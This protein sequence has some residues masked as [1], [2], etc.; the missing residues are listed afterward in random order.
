MMPFDMMS[1]VSNTSMPPHTSHP[2][3]WSPATQGSEWISDLL[4]IPPIRVSETPEVMTSMTNHEPTSPVHESS[5]D[6]EELL[7]ETSLER[8]D[9]EALETWETFFGLNIPYD[10]QGQKRY[11]TEHLRIFRAVSRLLKQGRT[12]EDIRQALFAQMPQ[13]HEP[14]P[15]TQTQVTHETGSLQS[16]LSRQQTQLQQELIPSNEDDFDHETSTSVIP[17]PPAFPTLAKPTGL[18]SASQASLPEDVVRL[19]Q[20]CLQAPQTPTSTQEVAPSKPSHPEVSQMVLPQLV[21]SHET[22]D[23]LQQECHLL[24]ERLLESEKRNSHLFQTNE[25]FTEKLEAMAQALQQAKEKSKEGDIMKLLEDKARLHKDLLETR[26]QKDTIEKH[27]YEWQAHAEL[28]EGALTTLTQPSLETFYGVWQEHVVLQEVLLDEVGIQM[29]AR[30]ERTV[31]LEAGPLMQQFGN[32]LMLT[33]QY[34]YDN[35]PH[36]ERRE[37]SIL[38]LQANGELSGPLFV[39]YWFEK[40]LMAK[41]LYRF[42]AERSTV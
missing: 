10:A 23:R 1:G 40:R 20:R 41:A 22:I 7:Q 11:S 29:D 13:S 26:K 17:S 31:V 19:G 37:T 28:L 35:N 16:Y 25:A 14:A 8:L 32:A 36:W 3:T 5:S 38:V 34:H 15:P 9:S 33:T 21:S 2:V 27:A 4:E 24:H 30:R 18:K 12:L 42:S 39:E 6:A